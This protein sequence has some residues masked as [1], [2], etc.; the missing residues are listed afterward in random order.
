MKVKKC[1]SKQNWIENQKSDYTQFLQSW[2][3]GN[4]KEKLG[5]KV[6]RLQLKE[7]GK[8]VEQAL[9][10]VHKL[11]L[12]VNYIYFPR[13]SGS[14]CRPELFEF[15]KDKAVFTRLEPLAKLN[16]SQLQT[17]LTGMEINKSHHR[18]PQHT[19]LLNIEP[20]HET[21]LEDMHSKTR[22]N[23]RLAERKDVKVKQQ[24]DVDT[25][26]K[27]H[28]ETEARADFSGH[29][30]EYYKKMLDLNNT[31]QL[32]AYFENQPL[33]SIIL[34]N[35][36]D[37]MTYLHGASTREHSEKMA[38]YRVQWKG[39]KLA[40]QQDCK[41]YDFWGSAPVY[42]EEEIE[43]IDGYDK[44][45][46]KCWP[47]DH[48]LAGVTRFKVRFNPQPKSLPSAK[49]IIFNSFKYNVYKMGRSLKNII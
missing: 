19:L 47:A 1:K 22:Y 18:Q 33:A 23:I 11:K 26:Y 4:F 34:I 30:K 13:V 28:K 5:K 43:D 2:Q 9:G 6:L 37:T 41:Y 8:T 7:N 44:S 10:I 15:I 24:Q 12:G 21:L 3:W 29:P 14:A 42:K 20:D 31:F 27:L 35:V 39:I 25:F 48:D 32:I 46:G 16:Q 17:E 40:K 36:G 45:F 38:T 49:D